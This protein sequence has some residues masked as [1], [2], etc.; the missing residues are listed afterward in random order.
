MPEMVAQNNALVANTLDAQATEKCGDKESVRQEKT[1][2][3]TERKGRSSYNSTREYRE[4]HKLARD[5]FVEAIDCRQ[6]LVNKAAV[7]RGYELGYAQNVYDSLETAAVEN[8]LELRAPNTLGDEIQAF[9]ETQ[10]KVIS[11]LALEENNI[12]RS[13]AYRRAEAASWANAF[14]AAVTNFSANYGTPGYSAGNVNSL[15]SFANS[16]STAAG[17]DAIQVYSYNLG[18]YETIKNVYGTGGGSGSS[19]GFHLTMSESGGDHIA[20]ANQ[21]AEKLCLGNGNQTVYC[22]DLDSHNKQMEA[23][24]EKR[25]VEMMCTPIPRVPFK[26]AESLSSEQTGPSTVTDR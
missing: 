11:G 16:L 3:L 12:K 22:K 6:K 24:W 19:S 10:A 15:N 4:S 9:E 5:W 20:V 26:C 2:W 1:D 21:N 23:A 25:R 14:N 7:E 17:R 13:E 8:S 18:T